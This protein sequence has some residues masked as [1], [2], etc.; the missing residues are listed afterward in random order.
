MRYVMVDIEADGPY[1]GRYSMISVGA[2]LMT[3][4]LEHTFYAQLRPVSDEWLPKALGIS[5]FSR[6]E[7]LTFEDPAEVMTRFK[8]WVEAIERGPCWF[9]AD[10]AG[11]DWSF[12]NWYFHHFCGANPFGHNSQNVQSVYKGIVRDMGQD[13]DH[14]RDTTHSHN[15]L[16]DA[17]GN[18][19]ALLKMRDE[20]GLKI[21]L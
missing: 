16:D 14:L 6:E 17:K 11:F 10:N 5:G 15:A 20:L 1:P 13:F 21:D 3:E 9:I 7:T 19:E 4:A 12:V 2:V 18:A 8:D